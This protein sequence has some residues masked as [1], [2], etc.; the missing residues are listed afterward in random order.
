MTSLG[1]TDPLFVEF[2]R[3]A[4]VS[5]LVA[6]VFEDSTPALT[7][8][9]LILSHYWELQRLDKPCNML[10]QASGCVY[11]TILS[12]RPR[13]TCTVGALGY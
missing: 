10:Q 13:I 11:Q 12:G 4:T 2:G 7:I 9:R 8:L 3:R 1:L 5:K 6:G